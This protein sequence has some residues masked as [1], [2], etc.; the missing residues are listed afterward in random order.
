MGVG[1][2][3]WVWVGLCWRGWVNGS[4]EYMWEWVGVCVSV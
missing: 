2:Y 1:G 3:M 4:D